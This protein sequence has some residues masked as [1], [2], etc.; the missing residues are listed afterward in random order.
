MAEC[1]KQK[2][3]KIK[4]KLLPPVQPIKLSNTTLKP[5]TSFR[6]YVTNSIMKGELFMKVEAEKPPE[7][8]IDN[9]IKTFVRNISPPNSTIYYE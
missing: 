5:K 6:D 9:I 2:K 7:L 1:N 3:R 4:K 8:P